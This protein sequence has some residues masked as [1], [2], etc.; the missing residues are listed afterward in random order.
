AGWR[1]SQEGFMDNFA[2]NLDMDELK[3]RASYGQLGD[4]DIGIG[5]FDYLSGYRYGASTVIVDGENIQGSANTGQPIDN[6]SWY[7]AT[8]ADIGLDFSFGSG[9][10]TGAVDYF[11]RERTGLRGVRN[12]IFLPLELGY[13]L[14]D[15]N[16][17]KDSN[18]GAE[19]AVNWNGKAGDFVF[20]I[21]GNISYARS[22]FVQS[23]NPTFS[24]SWDQYR[25]SRE[26]RYNGIFWGYEVTGQFESFEAINE[27]AVNIDGQGN[28]TLLSGDFIY[29]DM[30]NDGKIDGYDERPIGYQAGALPSLNFGLNF[31]FQYKGFDLTADFS[32]GGMYAYNQN[33]EMRWPYQNGGN[34]LATMYDDRYHRE[35]IL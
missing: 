10:I 24:S 1:I 19:M 22:K 35:D 31:N 3:I 18:S 21:G 25:N 6:L 11:H 23:Y 7:V 20:R 30:N 8:I 15:E 27:Y 26:D 33:Y 28:K 17:N 5:P 9:K 29:K 4:D 2:N 32:G 34:L 14:T 13:G 16:L 12:D